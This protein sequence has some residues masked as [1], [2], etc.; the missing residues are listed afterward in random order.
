MLCPKLIRNAVYKI[1]TT[2]KQDHLG[3]HKAIHRVTVKLDYR[4]PDI[5]LS[6]VEQQDAKLENKVRK[7]TE[8]FERYQHKEQFLKDFS[9]TQKINSNPKNRR[10][11]LPI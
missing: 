2:K 8:M 5:R 3:T 1:Y 10:N 6:A 4:I 9:Q 11:F 7:L